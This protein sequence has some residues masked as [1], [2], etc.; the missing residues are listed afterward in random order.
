M[1]L[2]LLGPYGLFFVE[3]ALILAA[4]YVAFMAPRAGAGFFRAIAAPLARLARHPRLSLCVIG[5][6]PIVLRMLLQPLLHTPQPAIHD[7]YAHLLAGD[8]FAHGRLANIPHPLWIFFESMHILQQPTYASMYP[9]AQGLFLAAGQVLFARPWAG[10]LMSVGLMCAAILWML[11]G[12][13]SPSWAFCGAALAVIRVGLFSYWMNSYWGGAPAAIGG[14][15]ALGALP[16]LWKR[17]RPRDGVLLG[18]GLV[19]LANARPYEG[20]FFSLPILVALICRRPGFRQISRAIPFAGVLVAGALATTYYNWRVTGDPFQLPE[21][22]QRSQYGIYPNLIFQASRPTPTYNHAVLGE[23]Y[24]NRE[25]SYR[26]MPDSFGGFLQGLAARAETLWFFFLGPVFTLPLLFAPQALLRRKVAILLAC[27]LS[28]TAAVA[29]EAWVLSPHYYAPACCVMYAFIVQSLRVLRRYTLGGRA[30]G[31]ALVRFVPLICV[32]MIGVRLAAESLNIPL[33]PFPFT[34]SGL[35]FGNYDR[36]RVLA[37]LRE[38]PGRSLV[39]VRYGPRHNPE[40]E[41][42]FNDADIDRAAVVWAREM[43]QG[44][45]RL[46]DYFND[47]AVYLMEPDSDRIHVRPYAPPD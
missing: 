39:I 30:F 36:A 1:S 13:F 41:W 2:E 3:T 34:W 8:T 12:W 35:S 9:P 37:A 44:N 15:L 28:L 46:L 19:L 45:D 23:F 47:R 11:Q 25:A 20:F 21:Q 40:D 14:A 4:V 26:L 29:L 24:V 42:V 43:D 18:L 27:F 10:V 33:L 6:A 32:L 17:G 7:E 5:L 22:L 31:L 16:R 38:Q